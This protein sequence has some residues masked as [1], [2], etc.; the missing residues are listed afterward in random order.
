MKTTILLSMIILLGISTRAFSQDNAKQQQTAQAAEKKVNGPI[1]DYDKT[2]CDLGEL[3]QSEPGTAVFTLTNRGN[4][5]LVIA[6][7]KAS[8]GCTGLTWSQEPVLPGKSTVI[9]AKY[10]AAVAGN[11]TKT[12]TV[13]TNASDA[14]VVLQI[15][16]TVKP[17][18]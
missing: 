5:P 2:V 3:I 4:E 18:G 14:S 11:F 8:C 9:S 16:G 15:K 1:A 12:I 6:S 7:A 13:L 10:N 17:K